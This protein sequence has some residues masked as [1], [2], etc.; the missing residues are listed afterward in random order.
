MEQSYSQDN[1]SIIIVTYNHSSEINACVEA[2]LNSEGIWNGEIIIVD[3]A[4]MDETTKII[5][6][7][8]KTNKS[9]RIQIKLD[10]QNQNTGF[11][12]G[13]NLGL[14]QA[15]GEFILLLNPDTI[16]FP[17]TLGK[18]IDYLKKCPA[19][20][21]VAPQLLYPD[22][23][24]QP[25]C[26]HFPKRRDVLWHLLG[27]NS[28]F[29]QNA[30]FNRWK[31]GNFAHNQEMEVDQP[32]GAALM[33]HRK[34]FE[35]IGLLD[36]NFPMFFSDVDWCQRFKMNGWKIIFYPDAKLIHH[37]GTSIHRNRARMIWSSHRSFIRYFQKYR[38][39]IWNQPINWLVGFL[40]I[41]MAI[42]RIVIVKVIRR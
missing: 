38:P 31:M 30:I 3:N 29:P 21:I 35:S 24:I 36:E 12:H 42:I 9:E 25:S 26:R 23:R 33:T 39:G 4:S 34:A 22:G 14:Q 27:L 2:I 40:L 18:L 13:T 17:D 11:T 32:Q 1:L 20:G 10:A 15:S 16:V 19:V 5:N 37:Q 8:I 41:F 28:L 7:L 6:D